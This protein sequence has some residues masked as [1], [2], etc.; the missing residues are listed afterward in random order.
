[1]VSRE[2]EEGK[3]AACLLPGGV[4]EG[5]QEAGEDGG[6]QVGLGLGDVLGAEV[7]DGRDAELD[8]SLGDIRRRQHREPEAGRHRIAGASPPTPATGGYQCRLFSPKIEMF[9]RWL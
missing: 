8:Q 3:A 6:E 2:E 5:S 4:D 7:G 1:M 9:W